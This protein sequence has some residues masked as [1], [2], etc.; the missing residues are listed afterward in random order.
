MA[1]RL[2]IRLG[3]AVTGFTTVGGRVT[4]VATA[5]GPIAADLVVIGLGVRPNADLARAAGIAIGQ[6]GGIESR[7]RV[8]GRS[9]VMALGT[10]I[11][12][13]QRLEVARTGL[14]EQEAVAAGFDAIGVTTEGSNRALYYPGAQPMTIKLVIECGTGRLL[15]AQIT[16]GL[17][18]GKR[19]DV[20]AT[21]LW[22]EMTVAQVAGMDLSCAPPFS[23]VWDPVLLAAGRAAARLRAAAA[24][25][26][27]TPA[28]GGTFRLIVDR[29]DRGR[30][31][32]AGG[33][34]GP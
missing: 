30:D 7:H 11:T 34:G 23:P 20:L 19:I 14:T 1:R 13:F 15:G 22:N 16:G 8:S 9:V 29:G 17:G 6:A 24:A 26:A 27:C 4:A 3:T 32:R 2:V 10:A 25:D 21:A 12:R 33:P 5:A 28:V 31:H 18:A